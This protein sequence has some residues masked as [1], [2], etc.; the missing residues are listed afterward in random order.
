MIEWF[1]ESPLP[2]IALGLMLA[3]MFAGGY[4]QTGRRTLLV[5]AVFCLLLGALLAFL[6]T[7]IVT[8]REQVTDTIESLAEALA[9]QRE[10][11]V[12]DAIHPLAVERRRHAET[13][14]KTY[15]FSR[16]DIK[17][18]LRVEVELEHQPPRALATFNVVAEI[19]TYPRPIPRYV[20]L[21]FTRDTDGVWKIR[22]FQHEAPERGFMR[23]TEPE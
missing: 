4:L 16:V 8:D 11:E 22:D 6:E 3:L 21:E 1:A 9:S 7:K 17:N 18:N 19:T 15:D 2:G 23:K 14:L 5:V 13:I 20:E 12:L 10:A